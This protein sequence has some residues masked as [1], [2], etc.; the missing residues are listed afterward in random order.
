MPRHVAI[1]MDG[2]GRWAASKNLPRRDGHKAGSETARA[3]VTLAREWNIPCLTLYAFSTENWN[4]P[5]I[6]VAALMSL[7]ERY[8]KTEIP[9]LMR[10][11]ARLRMLGDRSRL[12]PS[13]RKAVDAAERKLAANT[14]LLL[15]IAFSYGARDEIVR[16]ARAIARDMASGR[17]PPDKID[18]AT[19]SSRLDTAGLPDVDLV[20]RTGGEMRLSNFLL[21]QAAY[22]EYV[23]APCFWPDFGR[24]AFAAALKEYAG[25]A[26]RFGGR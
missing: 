15:N 18:E 4:R 13:L 16:A 11:G 25:R 7:L 20:I 12:R 26:R 14:D 23:S 9:E 8:L 1:V 24:E 17:L 10:C 22:A 2:N 6:E 21:W 3:V 5:K 19:F